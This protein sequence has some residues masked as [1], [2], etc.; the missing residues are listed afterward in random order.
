MTRINACFSAVNTPQY[1]FYYGASNSN[2]SLVP[3]NAFWICSVGLT[4]ADTPP[5]ILYVTLS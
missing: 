4:V 3:L 5:T 2:A 1:V